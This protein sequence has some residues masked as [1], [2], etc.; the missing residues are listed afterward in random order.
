[1]LRILDVYPGSRILIFTHPGAWIPDPKIA[2]KERG[3]K[4]FVVIPF[5]V[6]T[7]FTKLKLFYF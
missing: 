7:D 5:L 1:V 3:E 2:T 6:A 4:N